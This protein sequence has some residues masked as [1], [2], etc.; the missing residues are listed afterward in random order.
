MAISLDSL[1]H[2]F[3]KYVDQTVKEG[4]QV[5]QTAKQKAKQEQAPVITSDVV[6]ASDVVEPAPGRKRGRKPKSEAV[7]AAPAA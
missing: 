1:Q 3:S 7:V 6:V 5:K 4:K 2:D